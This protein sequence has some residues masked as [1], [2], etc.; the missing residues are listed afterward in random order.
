[1]VG[2]AAPIVVAVAAATVVA[3]AAPSVAVAAVAASSVAA[4]IATVV[5]A[6]VA[7]V[8]LV[9]S[10]SNTNCIICFFFAMPIAASLLLCITSLAQCYCYCCW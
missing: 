1:M 8:V 9:H 6:D 7:A 4:A 10:S 2:V 3:V 5:A